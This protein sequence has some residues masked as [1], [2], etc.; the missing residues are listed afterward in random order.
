MRPLLNPSATH[1]HDAA[2]PVRHK[3]MHGSR[4][5]GAPLRIHPQRESAPTMPELMRAML[6][7]APRQPLRAARLPVPVA[8]GSDILL[9]VEACGVCRTDLH[10]VDG[11][12]ATHR[13]P[14]VPGHEIVGTV[15]AAGEDAKRFRVGERVGVP[16]LAGTCGVCRFCRSGRENLCDRATFTGY[17]RDGGFA[18]YALADER[19]CLA[20]PPAY[21]SLHAAPLLC[22]GLIG[23]RAYR[24]AGS[25]ARIGLYGFGAAAH[26]IVQL[27]VQDGREIHAFVR[28][29]DL[30]GEL[31]ARRLGAVWS[32]PSSD[33][34]PTPLDAAILFAPDGALVPIALSATDKGGVVVCAGI[35]MS[36]IPSFPYGL[37]WGERTLRSV[38]N[39]TRED[40][41]LFLDRIARL[42]VRTAVL[43]F[44]LESAN[45]ALEALRSGRLEGAAVLC[46][47]LPPQPAI[48]AGSGARAPG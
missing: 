48:H 12:L 36:G 37:L 31:F 6:L 26:I 22:A 11:D 19:Y 33:L 4:S 39:L 47:K 42:P 29:G 17:D 23:F 45:Q 46:P 35:H 21:D 43:P 2:P 30:A 18:E 34:P 24:M 13:L 8:R 16:W 3:G 5:S 32:G 9:E 25:A 38:A 27:A 1:P 44:P 10:I 41:N 28:P 15:V 14:L 7:D 40:G 20:L